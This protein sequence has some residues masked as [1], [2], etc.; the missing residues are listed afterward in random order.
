MILMRYRAR[1]ALVLVLVLV[2]L[3][4]SLYTRVTGHYFIAVVDGH[5]MEPV[6]NT[7]DIVFIVPVRDPREISVGDVIVFKRPSGELIIHRVIEVREVSGRYYYVTK[8]DNNFL[9]DPPNR[10]GEPGIDYG[11]VIGKAVSIDRGEV[12]KIPYIGV[13]PLLLLS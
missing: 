5:S 7:G 3:S 8:G 1:E 2:V 9:P 11:S 10:P 13:I 12:F 4:I 6:L